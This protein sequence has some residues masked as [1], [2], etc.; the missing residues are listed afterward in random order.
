MFSRF[1]VLQGNHFL[2]IVHTTFGNNQEIF[3][4]ALLQ[5]GTIFFVL[6][7]IACTL[8]IYYIFEPFLSS[9]LWS[10]LFGA[11]L[12]PLK[13]RC[14]SLTRCYLRQ[15]DGNYH[16]LVFGLF[17]LF[18]IRIVDHIIEFI[19]LLCIRRWKELIFIFMCLPTIEFFQSGLIYRSLIN[20]IYDS[21]IHFE[22][23]V[24]CCDSPWT[25]AVISLYFFAVLTVYNSSTR[26]KFFLTKLAGP[27][28]CCLLL[29]SSQ[30]LPINYRVIVLVCT[31]FIAVLSYWLSPN[32]NS[33]LTFEKEKAK[34]SFDNFFEKEQHE[35]KRGRIYIEYV[36]TYL[37]IHQNE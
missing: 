37:K 7:C 1:L 15:L 34:Q 35:N 23:H 26:W 29:Y 31:G 13:T 11:L 20:I 22:R 32:T 18:P 8:V 16:F 21:Y 30:I 28:W 24:Q 6:V 9:I 19:S 33:K 14:V 12:H 17:I 36:L 27:V 2:S 3:R 25:L 5:S 10:L 4:R